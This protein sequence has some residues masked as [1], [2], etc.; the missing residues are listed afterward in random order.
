MASKRGER[1]ARVAWVAWATCYVAFAPVFAQ[2]GDPG[3]FLRNPT[4][5]CRMIALDLR[6]R[7]PSL[8]RRPAH[9]FIAVDV[10]ASM[11]QGELDA[12]KSLLRDY[13]TYVVVPEDRITLLAFDDELRIFG[14]WDAGSDRGELIARVLDP[15]GV[16]PN[17][18]GS[19][20][21][22]ARAKVLDLALAA[23]KKDQTRV[24]ATLLITD[25]DDPDALP[26]AD[27]FTQELKQRYGAWM[28]AREEGEAEGVESQAQWAVRQPGGVREVY[29]VVVT[30]VHR[31]AASVPQS[32]VSRRV[33]LAEPY[34]YDEVPPDPAA[35]L[36]RLL[37]LLPW[38]V[39]GALGALAAWVW[40][41][42][43]GGTLVAGDGDRLTLPWRPLLRRPL[44]VAASRST[45]GFRLEP[46]RP[47]FVGD[48]LEVSIENP[49]SPAGWCA[50]LSAVPPYEVRKDDQGWGEY[51][52][53]EPGVAADVVIRD[54]AGHVAS[55]RIKFVPDATLRHYRWMLVLLGLFVVSLVVSPMLNAALGPPPKPNRMIITWE[56]F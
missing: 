47:D 24:P 37:L 54:D 32:A 56:P 13:L 52:T 12:A 45:H 30:S 5:A 41:R 35:G 51:V 18:W 29:L 23:F 55:Q 36:R 40:A 1:S 4:E 46:V 11:G 26:R 8:S 49:W 48:V 7:A 19:N 27:S 9:W 6:A 17:R 20:V 33:P 22:A 44:R 50:L 3:T 53:L 39:L 25:R 2:G 21:H 31:T 28:G 38:T 16:R 34:A 43:R 15:L 14:P 10:S 42:G